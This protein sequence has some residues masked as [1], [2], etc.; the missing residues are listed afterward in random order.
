MFDDEAALAQERRVAKARRE[1]MEFK[2]TLTKM[3]GDK[4]RLQVIFVRSLP[5]SLT[6]SLTQSLEFLF[7]LS[8]SLAHTINI[9][10]VS[11]LVTHLHV[12][13][14]VCVGYASSGRASG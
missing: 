12:C 7:F 3:S 8:L 4:G 13:V 11:H 6:P 5:H 9:F 2:E 10:L 1:Q 14:C